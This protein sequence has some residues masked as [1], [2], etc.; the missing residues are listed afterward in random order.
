MYMYMYIYTYVCIC[1]FSSVRLGL[2]PPG[3]LPSGIGPELLFLE[4]D[5]LESHIFHLYTPEYDTRF[6]LGLNKHVSPK[7]TDWLK[8]LCRLKNKVQ[9]RFQAFC[10]LS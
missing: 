5:N 1:Q 7:K 4:G 8:A 3:L 9:E 6:G 10:C 2:A